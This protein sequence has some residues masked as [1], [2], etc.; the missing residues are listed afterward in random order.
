MYIQ[1]FF[2]HRKTRKIQEENPQDS[3][4]APLCFKLNNRCS[5]YRYQ[6]LWDEQIKV[7]IF[8]TF[9]VW[10]GKISINEQFS[11][12]NCAIKHY[13]LNST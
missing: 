11:S 7:N 10:V 13:Y 1:Y 9:I 6:Y 8:E 12:S 4:L 5:L 2:G 3:V